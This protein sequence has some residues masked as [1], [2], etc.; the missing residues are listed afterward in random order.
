MPQFV[1]AA[2]AKAQ[3]AEWGLAVTIP[4]LL[5]AVCQLVNPE[6]E[7][8]GTLLV[9]AP[10]A[11]TYAYYMVDVCLPMDGPAQATVVTLAGQVTVVQLRGNEVPP[12]LAHL[13]SGT[14]LGGAWPE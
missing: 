10:E 11:G 4:N 3:V 13:L 1:T 9:R 5:A 7:D 14:W 8:G 6:A 12:L 2:Q